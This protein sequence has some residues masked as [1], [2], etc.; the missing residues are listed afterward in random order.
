MDISVVVPSFNA[1]GKLER[2]LTSLRNQTIAPERYEVIFVD[3]C[4]TDGTFAYLQQQAA[5]ES[6]WRV[7]QLPQNSGSPSR[8]RNVGTA[9]A[10]GEYVF[11][12][13]CDDE[14]LPDTLE[15]HYAH[16]KATNA[17]IVRGYLL[18]DDGKVQQP[19]NQLPDW[20]R[21]A[22]LITRIKT[23][24]SKQSTTVP[25][26][27]KRELLVTYPTSWPEDI[28]V[29]EDSIFL[30]TLLSYCKRVEYLD[31]PTFIYNKRASFQ[32]SSTQEYG[33]RELNN[34]LKVWKK[35]I[36]S[37]ATVGIDYAGLRLRVGLQ[38]AIRGLIYQNKGDI[39]AED[40]QRFSAFI[41]MYEDPISKH[42]FAENI[43]SVLNCLKENNYNKF[44]ECCKPKLLI[45]GH[46]LKF[47]T[48]VI[49]QLREI[50][51]IEV[52]EWDGHDAHDPRKSE[53]LLKWADYIWCEWLLGNAVWYA[54]RKLAHQKLVI[55]MHRFELG[56]DFGEKL[57]IENVDTIFAVSVLFFERLLERFP[58]IPREK[59][60]LLHNYVDTSGYQQVSSPESR[61]N[62]AMIGILPSRKGFHHGIELLHQLKQ[63]DPRYRLKIFGKGPQDLPW[64]HKQQD[65]MTYYAQCEEK[66][67][68]YSLTDSVD[69]LGH[70]DIKTALAEQQIGYVLSLSEDTPGFP[71]PESFHLA[72]ADGFAA[73]AE[74]LI[75]RWAG[76]EYVYDQ[77]CIFNSLDEIKERVLNVKNWVNDKNIGRN[78]VFLMTR[79]SIKEFLFVV[80][81]CL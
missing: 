50:Y 59:V 75:L 68:E 7:L 39:T 26:F 77:K 60:R 69:F 36:E 44:L 33:S 40:F 1:M 61:F 71:G 42:R 55:R 6:N 43:Q 38:T 48:P 28:R 21:S 52:D 79:Y 10:N 20:D 47:I 80:K 8:P 15:L 56:R 54:E 41:K 18:A 78:H 25:S 49:P 17:C 32:A 74:S 2:C 37:L 29:G 51:Q 23:I 11:F 34:H 14:I 66:I 13:D 57:K 67:R 5:L 81:N 3:D 35:L 45:A 24:I 30:S 12:L 70:C 53:K 73:G 65:E 9:N 16:A 4:S 46:D 31:H 76:C 64:L 27:I 58:N 72:V 19:M 62:L 22:D 63:H